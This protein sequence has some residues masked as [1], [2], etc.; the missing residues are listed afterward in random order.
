MK[1]VFLQLVPNVGH[2]WD[3]KEI[4]DSYARNFLI[5][6]GLAKKLDEKEEEKLKQ[7][8]KKK[9]E[10]RRN[11]VENRH[12]IIETLNLKQLHFKVKIA[13]NWKMFGWIWEHD[14]ID[15]IFKDF[16]IKL[17]KKHI[18]MPDWHIKKIWKK[19]IF[20]KLSS[21]SMAKITII[22]E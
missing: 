13:E 2:I 9:E 10:N 17:E 3:I 18:D 19:D 16:K 8:E 14:I 5:P 21:D 22:V 1:V 11:L 7:E 12:K 15:K 4:S 20:I 6:K